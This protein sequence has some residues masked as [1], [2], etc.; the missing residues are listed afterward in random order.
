MSKLDEIAAEAAALA[1]MQA[2][3]EDIPTVADS[4]EAE[5][6]NM[7]GHIVKRS[8]VATGADGGPA[9]CP[10]WSITVKTPS[11]K[12]ETPGCASD[13]P[14]GQTD[15]RQLTWSEPQGS[16][17]EQH[18]N[19]DLLQQMT[20]LCATVRSLGRQMQDGFAAAR[21]RRQEDFAIETLRRQ[22]GYHKMEKAMTAK[23]EESLKN[24]QLAR[25]QAQNKI[26]QM[27]KRDLDALKQDMKSLHMGSWS[28]ACSEASTGVGLG[29]SGTFA[30]PTALASRFSQIFIPRKVEFIGWVADHKKCSCQGLTAT[31]VSNFIRAPTTL[32]RSET[33]R[34][35]PQS[36]RRNVCCT[37]AI[38]LG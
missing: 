12:V 5:T 6:T 1:E 15:R 29:G 19:N 28:T 27:A 9:G 33:E 23:M 7:A 8:A 34:A 25:Q 35:A 36:K 4:M 24:E 13:D 20:I 26:Q 14:M 18:Q 30:R 10:K 32:H 11:L 21:I 38:G 16:R 31:E 17:T 2:Q 3:V 22:D 37:V